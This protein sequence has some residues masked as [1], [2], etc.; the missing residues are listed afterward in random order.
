MMIKSQSHCQ[1]SSS[2]CDN[3]HKWNLSPFRAIKAIGQIRCN[4]GNAIN[5]IDQEN[6]NWFGSRPYHSSKSIF[7]KEEP[8]PVLVLV[9]AMFGWLHG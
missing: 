2:R 1:D 6:K 5:A 4:K 3:S 8:C 7:K 9:N